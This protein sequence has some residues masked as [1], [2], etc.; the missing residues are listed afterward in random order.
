[1]MEG[2]EAPD[3]SLVA[4][5]GNNIRL[6]ALR[7]SWV[8]LVFYPVNGSPTCN[9]QLDDLSAAGEDLFRRGIR[10]FGVNTASAEKQKAYCERRQLTFPILSDPGGKVAKLF[11]CKFRLFSLNRR[12]V[13]LVN[14]EGQVSF[15]RRG[16]PSLSEI[17]SAIPASSAA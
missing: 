5:N 14:P 11:C 1:M 7:P 10:V 12:T 15:Y 13:V 17:L 16:T 4:S 9:R 2:K 3:F 6:V 8:L